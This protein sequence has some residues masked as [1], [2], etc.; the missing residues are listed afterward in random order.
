MKLA[1]KLLKINTAVVGCQVDRRGVGNERASTRERVKIA[2]I[3]SE[4][5]VQES[6]SSMVRTSVSWWVLSKHQK[7]CDNKDE[8]GLVK[9]C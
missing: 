7:G 9:E 8:P 1:L 3:G 5:F 6:Y 4:P 2:L